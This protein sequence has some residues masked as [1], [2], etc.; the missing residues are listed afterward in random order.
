MAPSEPRA[1]MFS[2]TFGDDMVVVNADGASGFLEQVLLSGPAIE[3][4]RCRTVAVTP[5]GSTVVGVSIFS[6]N[7]SIVD[8]STASVIGTAPLGQ[9]PSAV[10]TT[11]DGTR[12]VVGNLDST[13]ATVVDLATASSVNVPIS[14]RAGSVAISPDSRFA[15][16]GVLADGD[17]VWRIDLDTNSVLGPKILT[18]NMG[19]VGYSFS[20]SSQIALSPDGALLAVAGTFTDNVSIIDTATWSL[21]VNVPVGDFPTWFGFS[22]D[23]ERVFVANKNDDT[24][25]EIDTTLAVPAVV[26]TLAAGDQPWQTV[27]TD[28]AVYV[29]AWAAAQIRRI[30]RATGATTAIRALPETGVG[31]VRDAS[32]GQLV[33]ARG[34]ATTSTGGIEGFSRT[35][36]GTLE[37]LDPVTLAVTDTVDLADR[38]PSAI[39][40]SD[41]GSTIAVAAPL[42]DGLVLVVDDTCFADVTTTGTPNGV[43]DGVVDLSDFSFYLTLWSSQDAAADITTSGTCNPGTGGD[44]VNLSDFSCYLSEWSIGCP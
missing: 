35:Q 33:V 2:T 18:G 41:S 30:D 24:L 20:Q 36:A 5:D 37:F 21:L 13:F 16:L 31:L 23:S 7:A 14:R 3:G 19:G 22:P 4:D 12:A 29:H 42:G 26:R 9:R 27:I 6:D 8:A 15:Y 17:G 32:S 28:D 44:G 10:A 25:S 43:P 11:P 39:A 34:V 38:G 40:I 1:A